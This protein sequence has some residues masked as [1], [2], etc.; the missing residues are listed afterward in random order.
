MVFV[1]ATKLK[2]EGD[3]LADFTGFLPESVNWGFTVAWRRATV[4]AK[5]N[6]RGEQKAVSYPDLG[7]D[8]F[9]YPQPRMQLDLSLDVRLSRRVSLYANVRNATD[10]IQNEFAY[11]PQTPR[12][13]R[14][15]YHGRFGRP[16]TL[17]LKGAF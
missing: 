11:G 1:N 3:A 7:P 6:Y 2:L 17:G 16:F 12:H 5:W 14:E 15:F 10:E 4:I 8:A 9:R 13:A